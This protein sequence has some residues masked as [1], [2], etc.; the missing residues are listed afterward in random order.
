MS[1][2]E[3]GLSRFFDFATGDDFLPS[4]GVEIKEDICDHLYGGEKY[5][6]GSEAYLL[7]KARINQMMST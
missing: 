2:G 3:E 5:N 7:T 4:E 1:P 6:S